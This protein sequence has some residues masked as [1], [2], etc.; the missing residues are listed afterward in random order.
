MTKETTMKRI[1]LILAC[2]SLYFLG[3]AGCGSGGS[4]SKQQKKT[5][6]ITFSTGSGTYAAPLDGIQLA[7]RLPA[8]AS[9]QSGIISNALTGKNATGQIGL[10]TY[11][12]NPPVVSFIVNPTSNNPIEF[13]PF[14]E[15]RCD[16]APGITL[17][18]GSFSVAPSD[19][20]MTGK[21]SSGST[22]HLEG[23]I[24]V[25]LSVAFGY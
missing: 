2:S 22:V 17:D 16:I 9:I 7:M 21:D 18:Q 1:V 15:L 24:P 19:I 3:L 25:T 4:V 5:A 20:Q 12:D 14:A 10:M 8:G 23:Q 13:G 6:T 11:T